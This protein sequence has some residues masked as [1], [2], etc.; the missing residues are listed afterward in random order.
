MTIDLAAYLGRLGAYLERMGWTEPAAQ[1][2][3]WEGPV[4]PDMKTLRELLLAHLWTFPF[5]NLDV[6][7]GRPIRLDLDSVQ[8]KL[9]H[10]HRGGYCFEH[11]TLFAAVLEAMGYT[12]SRHLA[13]VVLTT[14]RAQSPRTHMFI[15]VDLPQGRFIVDPG[16]GGPGTHVPIILEDLG[17]T[18]PGP[19]R[20]W[21]TRD[22]NV[23]VLRSRQ[24]DKDI[25]LWVSDLSVDYAVDFEMSSQYVATHPDSIF[26]ANLMMNR[27][28]N[29]GR[30]SLMN[31]EVKKD[32]MGRITTWQ[33]EDRAALH[34]LLVDHFGID[35]PAVE[36]MRVPA[37]PDWN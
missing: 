35:L 10:D 22:G 17:M 34:R 19:S 25:D 21:M 36:T 29:G 18:Q 8:R 2:R 13:R 12:V 7:L 6:L 4:Q 37:V 20:H 1:R 31:R 26:T 28:L 32:M 33:L 16:F 3:R 27:F 15:V 23:W 11:A 5:E 24:G 9:V 14:P 30:I